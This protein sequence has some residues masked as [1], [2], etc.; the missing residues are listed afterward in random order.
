MAA[1]REAHAAGRSVTVRI[2]GRVIQ[3]EPG[4]PAS[5]M[6]MFG[7]EGFLIGREA[8]STAGELERTV[9]HELYRLRTSA[10]SSG[11]SAALAAEETRAA[12]AFAERA[13]RALGQ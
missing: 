1:I 4:L 5:G 10:S 9:L 7:D 8:F 12:A 11:V 3:Y 2:G 6:T 13:A